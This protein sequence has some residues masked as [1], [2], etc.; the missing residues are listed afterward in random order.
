MP[1]I[2]K[3]AYQLKAVR[4]I[5]HFNGRAL[6]ADEM[7]LGK[8]I[9][10]LLWIKRHPKRRPVIIVCPASLKW[11][12]E[13][14]VHD[15]LKIRCEI[16]QGQTP[17]EPP[18]RLRRAMEDVLGKTP[19]F[20]IVNYEILQHW[21]PHLK[22]LKPKVLI[23]D[24]CHYQKSRK[25]KR[26]KAVWKLS[27]DIPHVIALSGTPLTNRPSEL[28]T[29]LRLIQPNE[30]KSFT[31][32]AFRYCNPVRRPWG[33]EYKGASNLGELHRKL[34]ST[35][36]I[37]RLKKD[38]LKELPDKTRLIVPLEI[39]G[40]DEYY[41]AQYDFVIWLSKISITKAKRAIKAEQLVKMGY[42]KRLSAELKMEGVLSWVDN[43][44]EESGGKLVLFC[45]H[46]KIIKILRN[47]YK[48]L[49][50]VVDGSVTG[51]KRK[52]AVRGFQSNKRI[53]LFIGN[54]RAAGV[55]ITLTAAST[56][57]FVEMDWTPGNHTQAEDRI[58]RIGQKNAAMIYYLIAKGTIE[59]K[60][61]ELIQKKQ[62]ILAATLDGS[63]NANQL[64]IFDEL[65][66]ALKKGTK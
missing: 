65:E 21:M 51:A 5:E 27:K 29:T 50:V 66:K 28:W 33:W 12:W 10:A 4:K 24:E 44:L 7:G 1:K 25:A 20:I 54:I 2:K 18:T 45:M 47:K 3:L 38:V 35:M 59:E 9:E 48:R 63:A 62:K 31:L 34:H 32:F 19:P 22:S 8:S 60:L 14:F 37:R 26:T 49:C 17:R 53:R 46:K 61:C 52:G 6:L 15:V 11:V 55:G 43:F 16:L 57:A 13:V 42:L 41:R 64:N 30:F 23:V 58:H 39:E 56:L 40:W 36:M